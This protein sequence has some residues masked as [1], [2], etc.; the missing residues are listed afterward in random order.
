MTCGQ[1]RPR[2]TVTREGKCPLGNPTFRVYAPKLNNLHERR[3]KVVPAPTH[4]DISSYIGSIW[5]RPN[6]MPAIH[7]DPARVENQMP[8]TH[9]A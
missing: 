9:G 1:R 3:A 7:R 8:R 6:Y 4:R 5:Y 2:A